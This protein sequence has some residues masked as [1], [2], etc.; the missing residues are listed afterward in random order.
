MPT[1]APWPWRTESMLDPHA[2]HVAVEGFEGPLD[3]LLQLIEEKQLDIVSVP[4][5]DLA[6]EYLA[7][8]QALPTLPSREVAAFLVIGSRLV[9]IKARSLLP[10]PTREESAETEADEAELRQRLLE[11][12]QVR[13]SARSLRERLQEGRRGFH[14]EGGTPDLPPHGGD[15]AALAAAW[16]KVLELARSA[17]AE[18]IVAP[19]ERYS[20]EQRT[21]EIEELLDVHRALTFTTLLGVRPTLRFAIVTF[22]ALL[23]LFRRG[24]V[25]IVQQ[26]LFGEIAVVRKEPTLHG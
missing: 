6:D 21:A 19:A 1:R 16:N 13:E 7:R 22:V 11:Y 18:E 14:R 5:G 12:Q 8:V 10:Q 9:L 26:E 3:L 20:V 4:L 25:D 15:P 17:P 23:D 24:A 2:P